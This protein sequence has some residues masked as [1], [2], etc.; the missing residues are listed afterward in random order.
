MALLSMTGFGRAEASCGAVRI[1]VEIKTV[2]HRFLD[3]SCRLPAAYSRFEQDV[4]KSIRDR[5]VR[6]HIEV[7]VN[8]R[9]SS[10]RDVRVEYHSSVFSSCLSAAKQAL[11]TAGV[12][13]PSS[14]ALAVVQLLQ[15]REVL[16]VEPVSGEVSA[17][18]SVLLEAV[19]SA[20]EAV[21]KMRLDE[22]RALEEEL[23]RRAVL[24]EGVLKNIAPLGADAVAAFRTRLSAKLEKLGA[25]IPVDPVRLAQEAAI[26]AE[27]TDVT[28]ELARMESHLAQFRALIAGNGGG[29]KLDFLIQEMS[30]DVNTIGSKSQ[31]SQISHAVVEAKAEL[32]KIREQVQNIE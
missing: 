22:G 29:R 24:V 13:D 9:D 31:H 5:L 3:V 25:E 19:S 30:R 14:T 27:R 2:N 18:R 4:V 1:E 20:L 12:T 32:E 26:L 23:L 10:E 17:E 21:V 11:Q 7:S 16:E 15:R 6:G 8:R 28:E